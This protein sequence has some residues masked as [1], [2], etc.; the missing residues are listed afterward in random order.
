MSDKSEVF[1]FTFDNKEIRKRSVC[2]ADE[3]LPEGTHSILTPEELDREDLT[4]EAEIPET[5]EELRGPIALDSKSGLLHLGTAYDT[6][7]DPSAV[8]GGALPSER[9]QKG[10]LTPRGTYR[11]H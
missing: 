9:T 4:P 7:V 6:V 8:L 3:G 1:G 11:A 2:Y 5:G 10:G